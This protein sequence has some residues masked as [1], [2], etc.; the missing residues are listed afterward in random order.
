MV[1]VVKL[2]LRFNVAVVHS[3]GEVISKSAEKEAV[4]TNGAEVWAVCVQNPS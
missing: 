2:S 1:V 3:L 4:T